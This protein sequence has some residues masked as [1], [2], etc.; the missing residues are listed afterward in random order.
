MTPLVNNI[1]ETIGDYNHN[2][3][4]FPTYFTFLTDMKRHVKNRFVSIEVSNFREVNKRKERPFLPWRD[5][6]MVEDLVKLKETK[7]F[8]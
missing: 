2:Y 7:D 1:N 3:A 8:R 5:G 6:N 4:V